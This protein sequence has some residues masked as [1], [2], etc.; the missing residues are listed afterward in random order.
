VSCRARESAERRR[1]RSV[2]F[3][4][5]HHSALVGEKLCSMVSP[6]TVRLLCWHAGLQGDALDPESVSGATAAGQR[7]GKA[8]TEF[9]LVLERANHELNGPHPSE[10]VGDGSVDH[11]PRS[12][13]YAVSE[14]TGRLRDAEEHDLAR[15]I[16][17]AWNAVLAGDIDDIAEHVELEH[18]PGP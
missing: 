9:L 13:A 4:A 10:R 6:D 12:V 16:D 15:R 18:R 14:V 11:V 2:G 7:V 8:V 17:T 1:L 3:R 5:K